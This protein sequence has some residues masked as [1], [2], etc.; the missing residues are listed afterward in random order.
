MADNPTRVSIPSTV[1]DAR[2]VQEQ[3]VSCAHGNGFTESEVFAIRLALD[4]ALTN[5]VRHGNCNNPQKQVIVEFSC[6][7]SEFR[8]AITDEGCGFR[9][10]RL[11]DP[12]SDEN[13]ERAHGRG[14]MLMKAYMT[15][16]SFNSKGNCVTM[17]KRRGDGKSGV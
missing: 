2:R 17:L 10:E 11:P 5:A 9:P 4:E 3:A 7:K 13:I 14:V 6:N 12:T 8:I 16:V 15:E 1:E